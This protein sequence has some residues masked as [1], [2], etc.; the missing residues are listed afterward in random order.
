M[1]ALIG[2]D[3]GTDDA[4]EYGLITILDQIIDLKDLDHYAAVLRTV[5]P[6]SCCHTFIIGER[7]K[8]IKAECGDR[9]PS[10]RFWFFP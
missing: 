8:I 10:P 4:R 1:S 3:G 2:F 6:L 7:E 5:L 9:S